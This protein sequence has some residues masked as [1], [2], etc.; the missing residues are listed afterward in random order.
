MNSTISIYLFKYV[1]ACN[2]H[3]MPVPFIVMVWIHV[4]V[5]SPIA[6]VFA[7]IT[8]NTLSLSPYGDNNMC[9]RVTDLSE[10]VSDWLNVRKKGRVSEWT[11]SHVYTHLSSFVHAPERLKCCMHPYGWRPHIDTN[12]HREGRTYVWRHAYGNNTEQ[13]PYI[14]RYTE[15]L[16]LDKAVHLAA[17]CTYPIQSI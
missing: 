15:R 16:G 17:I 10:W 11:D 1:Y 6:V 14:Q 5:D 13:Q 9:I 8:R 12:L 7:R 4:F 2:I 3:I